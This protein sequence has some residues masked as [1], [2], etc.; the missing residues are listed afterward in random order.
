MPIGGKPMK[1]DTRDNSKTSSKT[2]LKDFWAL[3]IALIA[4]VVNLR[5]LILAILGGDQT[6]QMPRILSIAIFVVFLLTMGWFMSKVIAKNKVVW[7]WTSQVILLVAG[8]GYGVW[9]GTWIEPH[10]PGCSDY[11]IRLTSPSNDARVQAGVIEVRGSL[12][13]DPTTGSIVVI[14]RSPDGSLNWPSSTPVQTDPILNVWKGKAALGG[15][16]PQNYRIAV[17]LVGKSGRA[18]LEYYNK[19]GQETG[20]WPAIE[21]LPDDIEIC[22]QVSV[23]KE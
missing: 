7:L 14:I 13:K 17:A 6:T 10:T 15:E 5:D 1:K 21:V 9:I 3:I 2:S 11:G 22:D 18:L 16:A 8:F 12:A 19:V 23:V 4:L 20:Q